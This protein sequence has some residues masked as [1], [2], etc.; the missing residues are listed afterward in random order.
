MR[1]WQRSSVTTTEQRDLIGTL[2]AELT[3][4][5]PRR[6]LV[7]DAHPGNFLLLPDGDGIDLGAVA[8]MPRRLPR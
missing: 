3:F 4:D 1:R 6:L 8:P 5:A 7:G 2:L